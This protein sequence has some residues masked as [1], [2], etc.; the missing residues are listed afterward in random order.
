MSWK[1]LCVRR[2][3]DSL[4]WAKTSLDPVYPDTLGLPASCQIFSLVQCYSFSR[5]L[6][7][8]PSLGARKVFFVIGIQTTMVMSCG[9]H[10]V[11]SECDRHSHLFID[12]QSSGW[13]HGIKKKETRVQ[14]HIY[15]LFTTREKTT[16]VLN[17]KSKKGGTSSQS[18]IRGQH[19]AFFSPQYFKGTTKGLNTL[20]CGFTP[21]NRRSALNPKGWP[22]WLSQTMQGF[23]S[24]S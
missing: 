13:V 5:G 21:C 1:T 17:K 9:S 12:Y 7:L 19:K 24:R 22:R 18:L 15:R 3:Q 4:P 2:K 6:S 10:L 16:Q 23:N 14:K 11:S 8:F 20:I